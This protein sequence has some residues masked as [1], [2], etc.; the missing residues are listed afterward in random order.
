M[1]K[2]MVFTLNNIAVKYS[3]N[4]RFFLNMRS[5]CHLNIHYTLSLS[6]VLSSASSLPSSSKLSLSAS[7]SSEGG[8]EIL[9]D[10]SPIWG[11][12]NHG[13]KEVGSCLTS[14]RWGGWWCWRWWWW[15][16]WWWCDVWGVRNHGTKEVRS[17]QQLD[18]HQDDEEDGDMVVVMLVMVVVMWCLMSLESRN[19]RRAWRLVHHSWG[20]ELWWFFLSSILYFLLP[21]NKFM[22]YNDMS[23]WSFLIWVRLGVLVILE[24]LLQGWAQCCENTLWA[25]T[26]FLS[27]QDRVTSVKSVSFLRFPKAILTFFLKSFHRRHNFSVIAGR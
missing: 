19:W 25:F 2:I 14:R 15:W 8:S 23:L 18:W 21:S 16:W 3:L 5:F 22:G 10:R 17:N 7:P 9:G 11:V 12:R 4:H 13:T 20:H 1:P 24:N 27:P 6:S 26:S